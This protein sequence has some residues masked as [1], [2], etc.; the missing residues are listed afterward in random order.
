MDEI[1]FPQNEF[2][3]HMFSKYYQEATNILGEE[4]NHKNSK[5]REY[6]IDSLKIIANVLKLKSTF[7]EDK[8]DRNALL[9]ESKFAST[10][11]ELYSALD[12]SGLDY[13]AGLYSE[14]NTTDLLGTLNSAKILGSR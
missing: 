14:G 2:I 13:F 4:L 12:D 9:K 1:E 11:V 8:G 7:S 3:T 10:V 5:F 6:I